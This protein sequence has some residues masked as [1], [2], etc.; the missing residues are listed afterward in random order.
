MFPNIFA[1]LSLGDF[2]GAGDLK[3]VNCSPGLPLFGRVPRTQPAFGL[4]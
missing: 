3:L 4:F 1:L 2:H